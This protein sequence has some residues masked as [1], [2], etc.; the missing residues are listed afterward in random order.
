MV[1][2]IRVPRRRSPLIPWLGGLLVLLLFL[3][4][5]TSLLDRERIVPGGG[6]R[7]EAGATDAAEG[8]ASASWRWGPSARSDTPMVAPLPRILARPLV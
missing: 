8:V 1:R 7:P 5:I 2:E 6:S 4:G 3:W